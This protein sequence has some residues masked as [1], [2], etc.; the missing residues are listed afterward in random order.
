MLWGCIPDL[1]LS[2][3]GGSSHTR[4]EGGILLQTLGGGET[5]SG[6]TKGVAGLVLGL[7]PSEAQGAPPPPSSWN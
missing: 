3:P 4:P 6:P 1:F 2:S 5:N 7:E